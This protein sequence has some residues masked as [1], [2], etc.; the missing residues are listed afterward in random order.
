[1][2]HFASPEF[3]K[4][5]HSLPEEVRQLADKTF[6]LLKENPRHLSLRFER[7]GKG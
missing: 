2:R 3:W 7:K 4:H 6:A 1:M 5:Y